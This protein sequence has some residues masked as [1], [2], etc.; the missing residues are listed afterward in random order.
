MRTTESDECIY[1]ACWFMDP[2]A[3]SVFTHW[4]HQ[5]HVTVIPPAD[6]SY[7]Q[8]TWHHLESAFCH[9]LIQEVAITAV[10]QAIHTI[11][12]STGVWGDAHINKHFSELICTMRIETTI[13]PKYPLHD[14]CCSELPAWIADHIIGSTRMQQ[15]LLPGTPL[16]LA[17]NMEMVRRFSE[18]PTSHP[19]IMA[20]PVN[21][22]TN[23][24]PPYQ[25]TAS[26]PVG[27]QSIDLTVANTHTRCYHRNS[28]EYEACDCM[29]LDTCGCGQP[30]CART[31]GNRSRWDGFPD[32]SH[33]HC[34]RPG[35]S[36]R[37][38]AWRIINVQGSVVKDASVNN[39][40]EDR[41][42]EQ[43]VGDDVDS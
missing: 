16:T 14:H 18:H 3:Y 30:F 15:K 13:T 31:G 26:T 29:T 22:V 27:P 19:A 28:F 35:S 21:H 33:K 9:H 23:I 7:S 36:A 20:T 1:S 39:G 38:A 37:S 25:A 10:G 4:I 8:V 6:G 11:Y 5:W 12:Y 24:V 17:N 42:V 41:A 34:G 32:C 2:A 43:D 40:G